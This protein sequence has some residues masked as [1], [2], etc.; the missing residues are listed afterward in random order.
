MAQN[1]TGKV[2]DIS[3]LFRVIAFAKPYKKQFFIAALSAIILSFLGPARPMLIN[4]AI[5]NFIVIPD[6]EN[7]FKITVLLIALLFC[8]GFIQFFYIY[9]S[10]W[11]GQNVILDLRKRVFK[12]ILSLKMTYFDKTPIGTLVTRS[13]SDIETIADIFSQGLLVI[14]AELLKLVIVIVVMFYTDWRFVY[15]CSSYNTSFIGCNC[16]VQ[17]KYKGFISRCKK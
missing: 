4:Y 13:V 10:T 15:N 8:E 5:D 7:L 11:I 14:I 1:K 16:M 6:P 3:L 9:L 12:H 2:L 17:K